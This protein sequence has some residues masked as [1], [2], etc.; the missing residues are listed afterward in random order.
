MSCFRRDQLLKILNRA[1]RPMNSV[2]NTA[3]HSKSAVF[4][5]AELRFY[6]GLINEPIRILIA[7]NLWL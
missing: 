1:F 2:E 7:L 3:F 6:F 4:I 5:L